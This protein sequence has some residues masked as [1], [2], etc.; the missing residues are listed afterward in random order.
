MAMAADAFRHSWKRLGNLYICPPWNLI[1][2][3]LQRLRQEKLDAT[4]IAPF[5]PSAA[6][7]PSK[8]EMSISPPY[9]SHGSVF[10]LLQEAQVTS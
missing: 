4:L 6:W 9:R 2:Q 3:V 8:Q 1:P 10:S 7:F 5:W